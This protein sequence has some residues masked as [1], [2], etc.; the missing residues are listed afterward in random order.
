[1]FKLNLRTSDVSN[2]SFGSRHTQGSNFL[3]GDGSVRF[4]R[5]SIDLRTYAAAAT[6][7]GGE[8]LFLD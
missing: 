6:R 8:V 5:Q 2:A 3:L 7:N 4:V 1:M